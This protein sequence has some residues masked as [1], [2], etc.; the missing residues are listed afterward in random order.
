MGRAGNLM[1]LYFGLGLLLVAIIVRWLGVPSAVW[2]P[3][4][5]LAIVLKSIFLF[6]VFRTKN[7]KFSVWLLLIIIGV[8]MIFVSMLFKYVFPMPLLRHI[9][10]YGAILLK[11][12]GLV[13]MMIDKM[14]K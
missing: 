2:I 14:K 1:F 9:L 4:F 7:F 13:F 8:V 11:V 6:N 12:S 3:L 5:G 10:F